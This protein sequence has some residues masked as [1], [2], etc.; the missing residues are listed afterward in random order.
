MRYAV[1]KLRRGSCQLP[2]ASFQLRA[3]DSPTKASMD[4]KA[5][6]AAPLREAQYAT[7]GSTGRGEKS[8]HL[9]NYLVSFFEGFWPMKI[10]NF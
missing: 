4:A 1:G 6:F 8:D 10:V 7:Q 5:P 3:E 9:E 2:E